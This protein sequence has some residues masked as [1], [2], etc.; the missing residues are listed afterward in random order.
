M[1]SLFFA[2]ITEA[3]L[4]LGVCNLIPV[5]PLDGGRVLEA[6]LSRR[7][8]PRRARRVSARIGI[9]VSAVFVLAACVG[10]FFGLSISLAVFAVFTMLGALTSARGAR[11]TA[12]TDTASLRKGLSRGLAVACYA[13]DESMT[14]ARALRLCDGNRF[15]VFALCDE[16]LAVKGVLS[17]GEVRAGAVATHAAATLAELK[18]RS[19]LRWNP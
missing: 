6:L 18:A 2:P 16:G 3:N 15:C 9:S 12:L 8:G 13:V 10:V 4:C 5:Y 14:A 11:F 1:L 19:V 7:M 17:E